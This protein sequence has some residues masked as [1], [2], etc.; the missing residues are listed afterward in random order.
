MELV[1]RES[2]DDEMFWMLLGDA[3][4]YADADYWKWRPK[5][6]VRL[7]RIWRVDALRPPHVSKRMVTCMPSRID[8]HRPL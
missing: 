3:D 4:G 8:R 1:E 6:V 5:S 7:P 2:D